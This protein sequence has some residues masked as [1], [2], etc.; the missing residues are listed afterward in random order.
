M[1]HVPELHFRVDPAIDEATRISDAIR[2]ERE[3]LAARDAAVPQP[4]SEDGS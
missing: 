2:H 1:R 3:A 4:G